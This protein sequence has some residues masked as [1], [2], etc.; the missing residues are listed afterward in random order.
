MAKRG[1]ANTNVTPRIRKFP[2][3]FWWTKTTSEIA[4]LYLREM[5]SLIWCQLESQDAQ[6]ISCEIDE[7]LL[8]TKKMLQRR[9]QWINTVLLV[10]DWFLDFQLVFTPIQ[11]QKEC[12][13]W[14]RIVQLNLIKS[15][16][17]PTE[18]IVQARIRT[19][20]VEE[21]Y[22]VA[23]SATGHLLGTEHGSK[24]FI[25]DVRG[26]RSLHSFWIPYFDDRPDNLITVNAILFLALLAFNL[27]LDE[28]P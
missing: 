14:K 8:E 12:R 5:T 3:H 23:K 9:R 6:K 27:S 13:V 18:Y 25:V 4:P 16:Y 1:K 24:F 22:F 11:F 10:S 28:D 2:E 21:H 7:Q 26:S 15:N 20:G 19:I 17:M